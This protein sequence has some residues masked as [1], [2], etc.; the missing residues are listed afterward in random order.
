MS[1]SV[2]EFRKNIYRTLD[3]A[4]ETGQPIE[5]KR[6]GKILK[7]MPQSTSQES[8]LANLTPHDCINGDPEELVHVDWRETWDEERRMF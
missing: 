1:I 3:E 7:V 4:L 5:I 2:S 8:K 6:K